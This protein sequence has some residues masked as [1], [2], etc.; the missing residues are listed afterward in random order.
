MRPTISLALA[1]LTATTRISAL[2]L[3]PRQSACPSVWTDVAASFK[4]RLTSCGQFAHTLIRL[5]FHDC[6][7][8]CDGSILLTNECSYTQN[9]GLNDTCNTLRSMR[10]Q[11]NVGAADIIQFGAALAIAA[12]P[13]GPRVQALVGRPDSTQAAPVGSLPHSSDSPEKLVAD[14]RAIGISAQEMIALLGTH[15]VA[16]QL[17]DDP[18]QAGKS[19][20]STPSTYDTLYYNQTKFRTAPYTLQ[21]DFELAHYNETADIWDSFINSA[22]L[23]NQVFVPAWFKLSTVGVDTSNLQDCSDLV[24]ASKTKRRKSV[25]GVVRKFRG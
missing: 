25:D 9:R 20:D 8:G 3:L 14:F 12:C 7:S 2:N 11:F 22:D 13:L 4:K 24:P 15:S 18:K 16:V 5:A 10:T 17:F 19:L 21:S 23:W 6:H 1:V